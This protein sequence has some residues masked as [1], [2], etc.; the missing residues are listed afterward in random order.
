MSRRIAVVTSSR[1][2]YG[3]IFW[4]MREIDRNPL[5]SLELVVM[6][7]HLS[8]R[9][10]HTVKEIE[11]DGFNITAYVPCLDAEDSDVG[12]ARTMGF[13]VG[14]LARIFADRRPDIILIIADR[15]EMLAPA[16][17]AL[18]LRIPIAH[19]EGG[20]ISEGAIDDAV[21]NALTKMAHLHFTPTREAS[22]R[23]MSMGEESW[24]VVQSGAPSIDHLRRSTLPEKGEL[25]RSLGYPLVNPVCVISQHPV[26]LEEDT[27]AD[28]Q[29]LLKA[30]ECWHGSFIFCFPNADVGYSHIIE[31]V[32]NFCNERPNATLHTNLNHLTYWSLLKH[33]AL[34]IGNSSSG[35]METASMKLP[36]IDVGSRQ[37]GRTRANNVIHTVSEVKSIE[38]AIGQAIDQEFKDSLKDL[39]NPYGDGHASER[40][41]EKLVSAPGRHVLLQKKALPLHKDKNL[42]V[43]DD[44][45]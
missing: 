2:D 23:V 45:L 27:T 7:A 19:I 4:P 30:L 3:H 32:Q 17:V 43:D 16:S 10:G 35:I 9:F 21:R 6:G 12:M 34:L 31:R 29:P 38:S 5:L 39:K 22:R 37:K 44:R 14:E 11:K 28:L 15:Y 41:V 18:T 13:A 42:F 24:R 40:I 36:T 26:T 33:S 1:A 8:E 20:D 25:E